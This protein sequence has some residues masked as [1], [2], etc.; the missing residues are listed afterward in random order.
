MR[1]RTLAWLG[2]VFLSACSSRAAIDENDEA[3]DGEETSTTDT[4][5]E[6]TGIDAESCTCLASL[7]LVCDGANRPMALHDCEVPN[8]CGLV[9]SDN[10]NADVVTCVLQL[11]VDQ[12]QPSRFDYVAH[13][14]G[15]W[16]DDTYLGTFFIL[17]PGA[18]IDLECVHPSYDCCSPPPPIAT[19]AFHDIQPPAYFQDCIGKT[20]SVMTGC[21]FNGLDKLDIVPECAAP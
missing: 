19:P 10:P 18:G 13:V 5:G 7:D 17:G 4:G 12:D 2:C 9:D 14:P 6:T 8:P 11:L 16:G 21:I 20:L 15:G 3:G 1:N